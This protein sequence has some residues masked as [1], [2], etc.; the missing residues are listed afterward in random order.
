MLLTFRARPLARAAADGPVTMMMTMIRTTRTTRNR[1]LQFDSSKSRGPASARD[2][3]GSYFFL[4]TEIVI[5]EGYCFE[6]CT[7]L[8]ATTPL[9]SS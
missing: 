5:S 3:A 8:F 2:F 6:W 7:E 9:T 1:D 4:T